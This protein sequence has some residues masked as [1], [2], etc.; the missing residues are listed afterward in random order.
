MRSPVPVRPGGGDPELVLVDER[1]LLGPDLDPVDGAR[2]DVGHQDV[3]TSGPWW[4]TRAAS[5]SVPRKDGRAR[6][7][8][9]GLP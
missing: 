1:G 6:S 5:K 4:V 3:G 8:G 9:R 2:E 7:D